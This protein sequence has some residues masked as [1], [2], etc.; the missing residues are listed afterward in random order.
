MKTQHPVQRLRYRLATA[1]PGTLPLLDD[2]QAVHGNTVNAFIRRHRMRRTTQDR[3][4]NLRNQAGLGAAGYPG[5]A[6]ATAGKL[7]VKGNHWQRTKKGH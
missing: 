7:K 4:H 5:D 3:I 6:T 1:L 2:L